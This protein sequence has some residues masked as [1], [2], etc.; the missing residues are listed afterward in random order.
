MKILELKMAKTTNSFQFDFS[1][2]FHLLGVAKS[3]L[4]MQPRRS[5]VGDVSA[6]LS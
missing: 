6:S 5:S 2:T 4:R 1:R 3:T